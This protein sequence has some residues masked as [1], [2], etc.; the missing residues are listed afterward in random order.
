MLKQHKNN[1]LVKHSAA[2][3]VNSPLSATERKIANI[4]LKNA[5]HTIGFDQQH[6]FYIRDLL[7][8]LGWS[9][10]S[11]CNDALKRNIENLVNVSLKW[12][13]LDKDKKRKWGVS[14]F[15]AGAE[16]KEG[17]V[18]Y[19]Y[20]AELSQ[21]LSN[22]NI[23]TILNLDYQQALKSAH[24]LILWEFCTEQLDTSKRHE[25]ITEYIEISKIRELL[26]AE[27]PTY[28][29]YKHLNDKIIKPA[30]KE[31]NNKTDLEVGIV[32]KK[33]GNK[34]IE[35]AFKIVRN[36]S[37]LQLEMFEG[38]IDALDLIKKQIEF[39]NNLGK[40][41]VLSVSEEQIKKLISS[42]GLTVVSKAL[43]IVIS[44]LKNGEKVANIGGYLYTLLDKGIVENSSV[45]GVKTRLF[46]E[47]QQEQKEKREVEEKIITKI[48]INET[49][50]YKK[51]ILIAFRSVMHI[52]VLKQ[53]LET[54]QIQIA[55]IS[56]K[57][58][59]LTIRLKYS[60]RFLG[61]ESKIKSACVDELT[62]L[63][64]NVSVEIEDRI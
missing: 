15:L 4:F 10:N 50:P 39:E 37:Q 58:G 31:I 60:I 62:K 9:E 16:I 3:H 26:G 45:E 27:E 41:K 53:A 2:V 13:I 61:Y 17:L 20:S 47:S 23:Y 28:D 35:I 33:V 1:T 64:T 55:S 56:E 22:P 12:N 30:I 11:E 38:D 34:V 29:K 36:S 21:R 40:G 25:I 57:A 5:F 43:D 46:L 59:I 14:S 49:D 44:K 7:K 18:Y 51:A 19:S 6:R 48:I 42:Y 32:T 52:N 54:N 24:G 63:Y 8:A